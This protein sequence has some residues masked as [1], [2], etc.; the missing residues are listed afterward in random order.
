MVGGQGP[1]ESLV[2]RTSIQDFYRGKTVLL[3]GHTGFKGGWLAVWLRLLG[4]KVVGYSL[5]PEDSPCLF[6]AARV[7][8][9]VVSVLG[10]LRDLG[11]LNKTFAEHKPEIVFHLAAQALVRRS[12]V[13]PLDTFSTNILGTAH[14]LEAARKTSSVREIVVVTSDKCYDLR[15]AGQACREGDP[16]GGHDP[17]SASKG[18]AEIVAASYRDSFFPPEN[19]GKNA[20]LSTARA[21]NV[22]GGGDWA[23][24]RLLPDCVRALSSGR[25][26]PVRNPDAVRPWQHV[27]E[28]LSGYLWLAARMRED[29]ARFCGAWNFGP[30]DAGAITVLRLVELFLK[31]WGAGED[32][33]EKAGEAEAPYE[34]PWLKL[35]STKA[36]TELEWSPVRTVEEGVRETAAWYRRCSDGKSFDGRAFTEEQ[37]HSYSAA[38]AD[39]GLAWARAGREAE[40]HG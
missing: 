23:E 11:S 9:G 26:V 13:S 7:A 28:P 15:E 32:A 37:I 17:Y 19:A 20:S 5:P 34:A 2:S 35:D 4:A 18:A 12:Y 1:L 30:S 14:V 40:A 24:D 6:D 21:G 16:L 25:P 27:L 8:D 38:A 39:K 29:P 36:R 31:E 22:I 3:T 33:W 10:D